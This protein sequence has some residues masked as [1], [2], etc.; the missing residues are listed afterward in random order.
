MLTIEKLIEYGADTADGLERCLNDE[1]F[2]L[3]LIPS[4]LDRANYERIETSVRSGDLD[5]AFE[6]A[7]A[8]KGVLGNLALTPIFTP[9]AELTELLRA[10]SQQD[11]TAL[12]ATIR[13]GQETL[14]RICAE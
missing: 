7:H 3:E 14:N 10:H 8:L 11:C 4:A 1:S 9:V 5:H 12:L 6:A 2:Y 13:Q